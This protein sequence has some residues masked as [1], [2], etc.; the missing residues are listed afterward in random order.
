MNRLF[1]YGLIVFGI[2]YMAK[3]SF[4]IVGNFQN[5]NMALLMDGITESELH[6]KILSHYKATVLDGVSEFY[7]DKIDT[8]V[9][10]L[11]EDGEKDVIAIVESGTTCGSGGCIASIFIKNELGELTAIPFTYAVK[12]IEVLDTITKGM[13][14]LRINH[15]ETSKMI[16]D[17][18]TYVLEQI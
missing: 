10:D 5:G 7:A 14:D 8:T 9:T 17:G 16:W 2:Y 4:G 15:D 13:H 3:G 12:N 1:V 11:N 6:E 18:T